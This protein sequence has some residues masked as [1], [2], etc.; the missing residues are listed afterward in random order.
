MSNKQINSGTLILKHEFQVPDYYKK[1]KCKGTECRNT[2]CSGWKVTI[3]RQQYFILHGLECNKSLRQKMDRAFRVLPNPTPERYAEIAH[4]QNGDCPLLM[5][6]GFCQLHATCGEEVLPWICRY[7]PRGPRIDYAY[8]ATIANS[9]ERTL[10]LLFENNDPITFESKTLT[11]KMQVKDDSPNDKDKIFYKDIQN[12]CFSIIQDRTISLPNRIREVGIVLRTLDKEPQMIL[13]QINLNVEEIIF[14]LEHILTIMLNIL[15]WFII[16]SPSL[17]ELCKIIKERYVNKEY[18]KS[19]KE[20][21][22]HFESVLP[23]HEI[24]FEKM[25]INNML[26]RQ[27][28][29]FEATKN[30]TETYISLAGTYVFL[31]FLA[32]NQMSD[33]NNDEDFIDIMSKTFRVITHTKFERNII[34]LL[35]LEKATDDTLLS[36]LVHI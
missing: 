3:A 24:K 30:F 28:P 34:G 11:F 22:N 2:C 13:N 4:N 21:L 10:E 23:D 6:N 27:F 19:Y 5:D 29:Y 16:N 7:Y 18:I 35:T 14:D 1:F 31:R 20:S 12:F 33:K 36:K 25:L 8:E 32:V 15:E 9:C 26:F 17:S